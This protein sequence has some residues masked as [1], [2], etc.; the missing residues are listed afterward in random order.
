MVADPQM[1]AFGFDVRIDRLV[2]EKLCALR[3]TGNSPIV[4]VE[5]SAEKPKLTSMIE[6]FDLHEVA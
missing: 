4:I 5:Q 3:C 6:E 2:I 1:I